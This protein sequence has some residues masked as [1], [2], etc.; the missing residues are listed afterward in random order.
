MKRIARG[1]ALL[2]L[3]FVSGLIAIMA[4]IALPGMKRINQEWTLWGGTRLL[5]SS[6]LWARAHA[7]TA[8]DSL[9][10]VVD[11]EG[12]RIYWQDSAGTRYLGSIRT[13]PAGVRITQAP[14]RPLCFFPRGNAVPAGTYV[15]Q[16]QA[17]S[18]RVIVS[19]MGRVRVMRN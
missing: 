4:A 16:G 15:V 10:L 1:F 11:S 2:E 17:G 19:A 7:I 5:E 3:V 14:R 12:Y 9:S 13:L 8:N 18:Y 6:L